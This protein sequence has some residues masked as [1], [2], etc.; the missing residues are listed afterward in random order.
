[1]LFYAVSAPQ[2]GSSGCQGTFQKDPAGW[3]SVTFHPPIC[4]AAEPSV[5]FG[6]DSPSGMSFIR[7]SKHATADDEAA[8]F[9]TFSGSPDIK[10]KWGFNHG[11]E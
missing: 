10:G 9:L 1:M 7:M 6:I 11:S 3:R 5:T 2:P 8:A 4:E